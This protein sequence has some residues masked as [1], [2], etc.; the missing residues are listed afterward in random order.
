MASFGFEA[1]S[2]GWAA[3][4]FSLMAADSSFVAAYMGLTTN[5]FG[6]CKDLQKGGLASGLCLAACLTSSF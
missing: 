1:A 6:V 4:G 3:A 5:D 2:F